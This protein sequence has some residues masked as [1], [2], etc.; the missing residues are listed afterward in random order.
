[1]TPE[2]QGFYIAQIV[3]SNSVQ[4]LVIYLQVNTVELSIQ[5]QYT[6]HVNFVLSIQYTAHVYF[7]LSI[8]YTLHVDIKILDWLIPH[9]LVL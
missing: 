1:M 8:Q 5:L 4:F 3:Y 6:Y 9:I 2:D 7:V